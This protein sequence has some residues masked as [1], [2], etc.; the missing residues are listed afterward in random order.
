MVGL[1]SLY[2][3]KRAFQD[4]CVHRVPLH[5]KPI[6]DLSIDITDNLIN[7]IADVTL[8]RELEIKQ[9]TLIFFNKNISL[10]MTL[11]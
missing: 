11:V 10:D 3:R 8:C 6:L 7:K 5:E 4:Y 2:Q 1:T 9:F